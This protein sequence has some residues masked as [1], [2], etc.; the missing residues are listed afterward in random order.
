M[1]LEEKISQMLIKQKKTLSLA[2]SCTGGLLS[3]RLTNIPGATAFLKAALVVYSNEA[4]TKLLKVPSPLIQKHGAVSE[5]VAV[6]LA[7]QVRLLL[8]TDFG[9]SITGIAG[10]SGG[11]IRKP[12]GLTFIA[13]SAPGKTVCLK[14]RL[15][16]TRSRIKKQATDKAL[17]LLNDFL[18]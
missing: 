6:V 18:K 12:V 9:V 3:H 5:P 17:R 4:K 1:R 15:V 14:C 8:K 10:P 13:L 16:G 7:K 11:S 2:E